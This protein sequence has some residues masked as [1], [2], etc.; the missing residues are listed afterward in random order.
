MTDSATNPRRKAFDK[1]QTLSL[2]I[3]LLGALPPDPGPGLRT[4]TPLGISVPRPHV[5][6][7]TSEPGY[8]SEPNNIL[9]VDATAGTKT[10]PKTKTVEC[11]NNGQ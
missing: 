8:A 3:W 9:T 4:W 1:L 6:T 2:Y 10:K 7:L 11:K 5:P